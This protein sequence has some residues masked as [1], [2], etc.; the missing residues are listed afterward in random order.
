VPFYFLA[1]GYW[2]RHQ[3]NLSAQ[4]IILL[5]LILIGTYFSHLMIVWFGT[6]ITGTPYHCLLSQTNFP[7][8]N[9]FLLL[10]S[11]Q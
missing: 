3:D 7:A 2:W 5:N 6:D 1:L 10:N 11:C 4:T 9:P 8:F